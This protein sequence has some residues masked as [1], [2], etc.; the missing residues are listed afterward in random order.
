MAKL[1]Y[2]YVTKC[3]ADD[4]HVTL[5]VHVGGV[6]RTQITQTL[7]DFFTP[8]TERDLTALALAH[9]KRWIRGWRTANPTGTLAQ[10]K[11][12]LEAQEWD[13]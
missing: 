8:V 6:E 2:R 10:L 5:S 13:V 1:S 3:G 4:P 11:T 9:L 12:A 7:S